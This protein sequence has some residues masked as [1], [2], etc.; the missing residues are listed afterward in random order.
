LLNNIV[1]FLIICL[2]L[3]REDA[4]ATCSLSCFIY[5]ASYCWQR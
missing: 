5:L 3:I 2:R 1:A 4:I